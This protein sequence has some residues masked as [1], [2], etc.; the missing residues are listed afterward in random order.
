[1]VDASRL[2]CVPEGGHAYF[3]SACD[4]DAK[5][6]LMALAK[7]A[8]KIS[9][10]WKGLNVKTCSDYIAAVEKARDAIVHEVLQPVMLAKT[11]K[12]QQPWLGSD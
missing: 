3:W 10:A 1:M 5:S 7:A 6:A 8:D 9:L 2:P 11:A 4:A 12:Y